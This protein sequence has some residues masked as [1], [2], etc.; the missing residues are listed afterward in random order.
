MSRK[1]TA[2]GIKRADV[3]RT[4]TG[5][6]LTCAQCDRVDEVSSPDCSIWPDNIVEKKFQQKGWYVGNRPSKDLCPDC[7]QPARKAPILTIVKEEPPPMAIVQPVIAKATMQRED[8]RIILAKLQDVYVDE[9]TGYDAGWSDLKVAE[10]LGVPVAW[11]ESLRE[12]NFGPLNSSASAR[13]VMNEALDHLKAC[14]AIEE[15]SAKLLERAEQLHKQAAAILDEAKGLRTKLD[16]STHE[17]GMIRRKVDSI[18]AQFIR[19]R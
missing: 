4:F 10:D 19:N 3:G 16:A 7:K 18:Q 15:Q 9:E 5:Y 1:Y 11:V 14:K 6:R 13:G 17:T 8:R 2:V 12:E